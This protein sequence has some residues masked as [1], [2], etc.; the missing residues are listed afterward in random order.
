MPQRTQASVGFEPHA[1]K[2][3][4]GKGHATTHTRDARAKLIVT[5]M[6]LKPNIDLEQQATAATFAS[7]LIKLT[8]GVCNNATYMLMLDAHDQAKKMPNYKGAVKHAYKLAFEAWAKYEAT[9]K[10]ATKY[11]MFSVDDMSE[12]TRKK[13]GD[14]TDAQY[15]DFWQGFGYTAYT[16]TRP[17]ITSLQNKYRLSLVRHN[18][19][20]A[21][22]ISWVMT[23]QAA[24]EMCSSIWK[25]GIDASVERYGLRRDIAE[26]IFAQFKVTDVAERWRRAMLLQAPYEPT[27]PLDD[28]ETRN[29]E[30]GLIQLADAWSEGRL[31]VKSI[32]D[33][34]DDYDEIF[35]TQGEL[36]KEK[37]ELKQMLRDYD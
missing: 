2:G 26:H 23:A 37:R 9:L 32:H 14:I 17:L 11:R 16:K 12:T 7:T 8:T 22:E 33:T 28:I 15:F 30:M 5:T 29:I 4:R 25:G 34:L 18:R 3:R 19:P 24:L 20:Y 36:K 6:K 27:E 13:Y 21:Y 31:A 1:P 10:Y 35:R